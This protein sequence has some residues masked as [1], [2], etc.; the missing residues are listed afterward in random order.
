MR[1]ESLREDR[2]GATVAF[3][4]DTLRD[5]TIGFLLDERP[6]LRAALPTDRPMPG[7]LARGLEIAARLA[8][9]SDATGARWLALLAEF[10]RDGLPRQLAPSGVDGAATIG[11]R[12]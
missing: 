12:A 10:E 9:E 3:W 11:K 5:W 8:L 2:A 7:T 1:V 6:E 4:H